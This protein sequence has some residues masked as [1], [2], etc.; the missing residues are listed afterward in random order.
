MTH[1]YMT[2]YNKR[3][4]PFDVQKVVSRTQNSCVL[5]SGIV[6]HKQRYGWRTRRGMVHPYRPRDLEDIAISIGQ[7]E[8]HTPTSIRSIKM[9]YMQPYHDYNLDIM[10]TWFPNMTG[11]TAFAYLMRR[12][13]A[14]HGPNNGGFGPSWI[15]STS[16]PRIY[17]C[18]NTSMRFDIW[19]DIQ[20]MHYLKEE[21]YPEKHNPIIRNALWD[22]N[23]KVYSGC[24]FNIQGLLPIRNT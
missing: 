10:K 24:E 23:T 16:H 20:I 21:P 4:F 14:G 8:E 15:L 11:M 6:A 17:L 3:G 19:H 5:S 2:L 12:F 13:G 22:L 9:R 1:D 7:N 18:I